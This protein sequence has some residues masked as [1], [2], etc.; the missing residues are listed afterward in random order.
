MR[1]THNSSQQNRIN[2]SINTHTMLDMTPT[3]Y[4][5][6]FRSRNKNKEIQ[7][8]LKFKDYNRFER[9]IDSID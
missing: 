3:N 6:E 8:N 9:V 4:K 2:E 1:Y 7:G 5:H